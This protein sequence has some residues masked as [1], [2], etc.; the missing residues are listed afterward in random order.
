MSYFFITAKRIF[1]SCLS[2]KESVFEEFFV[3]KSFYTNDFG[4]RDED[5][6]INN[7]SCFTVSL[8]KLY[9]N[10]IITY[11][12]R[13]ILQEKGWFTF[14]IDVD[15]CPIP[16]WT[17]DGLPYLTIDKLRNEAK[18]GTPIT[19]FNGGV[20]IDS[21]FFFG[22]VY[23]LDSLRHQPTSLADNSS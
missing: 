7:K 6:H 3:G 8:Q 10:M 9:Y 22:L 19:F 17:K 1:Y 4:S 14:A 11:P 21:C 12:L 18:V 13:E 16:F 15:N 2:I 23:N 5:F 20:K